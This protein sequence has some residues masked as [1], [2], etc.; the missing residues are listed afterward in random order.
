[1]A[2]A[3]TAE[4]AAATCWTTPQP[5]RRS[6]CHWTRC[7]PQRWSRGCRNSMPTSWRWRPCSPR[8]WRRWLC[9]WVG[10]C[11][12]CAA[13]LLVGF[14]GRGRVSGFAPAQRVFGRVPQL[15]R[16]ARPRRPRWHVCAGGGDAPA[17]SVSAALLAGWPAR[18]HSFRVNAGRGPRLHPARS[19]AARGGHAGR[20]QRG[21]PGRPAACVAATATGATAGRPP[22]G[23][24]GRSRQDSSSGPAGKCCQQERYGLARTRRR[25]SR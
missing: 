20:R 24:P 17:G 14:C 10:A 7:R 21:G 5:R 15:L 12:L 8:G 1:M 2:A 25:R 16:L 4:A 18:A 22:S 19:A 11:V 6:C 3:R 13:A 9:G 23:S